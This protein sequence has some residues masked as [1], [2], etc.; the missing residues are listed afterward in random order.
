[1]KERLRTA[2]RPSLLA[3]PHAA[4][5]P[6]LTGCSFV[7]IVSYPESAVPL[8]LRLQMVELQDQ[9]WPSDRR[10]GSAPWH[11]PALSPLS[12]LLVHER[13]VLAALDILSKGIVHR[14]GSYSASGLSAVVTDR[15]H[16]GKGHGRRIVEAARDLIEASQADL[17]IFTC[18]VGLRSFYERSGWR[19]LP[20]T[21]LVGGTPEAPFPSD[22]FDKVTMAAFFSRRAR[23]AADAFVGD[24]VELYP[25]EIDKLW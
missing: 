7:R 17:G 20:G 18:D 15:D 16:R 25:G 13:R 9:A 4:A 19:C 5:A 2:V 10:T 3:L 14:G 11:D 6:V 12:V 22:R 21:V 8:D 1:M 24:R 23:D